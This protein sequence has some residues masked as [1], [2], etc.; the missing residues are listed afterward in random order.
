MLLYQTTVSPE[1]T[2]TLPW[3]LSLVGLVLAPPPQ[4]DSPNVS[5]TAAATAHGL[6]QKQPAMRAGT[7]IPC[8]FSMYFPLWSQHLA[9]RIGPRPR[10]PHKQLQRSMQLR[11]APRRTPPEQSRGGARV[12][13]ESRGVRQTSGWGVHD[14]LAALLK[15][16]QMPRQPR[17]DVAGL[18]QLVVQR[19]N[20]RQPQ[21]LPSFDRLGYL[22][23]SL[24]ASSVPMC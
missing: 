8:K 7:P 1:L 4:P 19:G 5:A 3:A 18:P 11:D 9:A 10:M 23:E 13:T 24:Y 21:L 16:I 20:D 14:M 15:G 22:D 2:L 12:L 6:G 17:P